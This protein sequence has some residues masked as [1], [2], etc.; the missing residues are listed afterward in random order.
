MKWLFNTWFSASGRPNDL[1]GLAK[2]KNY[3]KAKQVTILWEPK[4]HGLACC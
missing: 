3:N 4:H 2:K 1:L